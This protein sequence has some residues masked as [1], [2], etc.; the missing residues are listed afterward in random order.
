MTDTQ[1]LTRFINKYGHKVPSYNNT[2]YW[3]DLANAI[4]WIKD[5]KP[6]TMTDIITERYLRALH[7][8]AS[9]E[10]EIINKGG[11]QIEYY[12]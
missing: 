3:L 6:D 9:I 8:I 4:T 2:E 7:E 10:Y 12:R 5:N 1:L 11:R